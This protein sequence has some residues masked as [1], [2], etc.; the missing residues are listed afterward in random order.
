M[1][2]ICLSSPKGG[3][4]KTTLTANLAFALQRLGCPVVLIDFDVQNALRLHLGLALDDVRGFVAPSLQ[5]GEWQRLLIGT[6]SGIR[7]LP[8]GAVSDQVQAQF[9]ESLQHNPSF[10]VDGLSELLATPGVVVLADTPPGPSPALTALNRIADV[11]IAVLLADAASISLLPGI[12]SGRFYKPLGQ[13]DPVT[14]NYI[15]NQVDRR[16]RLNHDVTE[17][18]QARLGNALLGTV[19]RDEALAESLASQQSIFTFEPSAA[20]AYDI[21]LIARRLARWLDSY[22]HPARSYRY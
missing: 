2:L 10:L 3:V 5:Q 18:L 1:P 22:G 13:G 21:D 11:R 8:Y 17:F 7:I 15:L 6:Q 19:H 4:G 12:E 9:E 14:V 20:S 16:R